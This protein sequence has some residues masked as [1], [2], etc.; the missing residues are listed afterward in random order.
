MIV[1]SISE[2]APVEWG[3]G[4]SHRLLTEADGMGFT[5][6]ETLVRKGTQSALQYRRHLEACYCTGGSGE[7]VTAS[8][9]RFKITE[10]TIYALDEHDP[11]YLIAS[12][13]EDLRLV[14]VFSPALRG[15]EKHT[16]SPDGFS[17]Y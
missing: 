5:V 2:L 12:D 17:Q 4:T 9:E 7:V 8:G 3:N 13:Y 11:H 16:L 14:S 1:R 15:D 10:G 6:C